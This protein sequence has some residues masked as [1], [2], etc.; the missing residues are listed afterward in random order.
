[1]IG[2]PETI[3][4][5]LN[6]TLLTLGQ[7]SFNIYI[8]SNGGDGTVIVNVTVVE[9]QPLPPIV[10]IS[11]PASGKLY[12]RDKELFKLA[13]TLL[14]GSIE[15]AADAKSVDATITKMEVYIDDI[16]KFN[17]TN[18]SISFFFNE[19]IFGRHTLKVKAYDSNGLSGI[20]EMSILIFNFGR[21]K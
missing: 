11:K 1:G 15:I 21:V 14:I 16:M 5:E 19:V 7:H 4:V 18:S 8:T 10:N 12:F 9:D 2:G 13:N 6:T 20:Q 3:Y 17:D